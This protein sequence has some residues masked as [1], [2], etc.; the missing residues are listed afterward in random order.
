[1]SQPLIFVTGATGF[2]G[3][4][5]VLQALEAGYS[6]RLSVRKESQIP[7]LKA[8]FSK[9]ASRID[10]VVIPDL[11]APDAF[12]EALQGAAYVF[13]LASPMLGGGSD[14]KRDHLDPAVQ[15]TT[16]LLD[17]AKAVGTIK[18]IVIVSSVLALIS[19]DS[20]SRRRFHAK[21]GANY[22]IHFDT[23]DPR[24]V[25]D[26]NT[27]YHAS[28]VL[29]HRATLEWVREHKPHFT[30]VTLHPV[31]VFGRNLLQ[32]AAEDLSG[33]NAVL[34]GTL[35]A[36]TP[37]II[38]AAVDVRDVA[39]AHLRALDATFDDDG[40]EVHEFLLGAGEARGWTWEKVVRFV[41]EKFP[42]VEVKLQGPFDAPPEVET[43]K[44]E[45]VLGIRWRGMEDTMGELLRQ[46]W[47]LGSQP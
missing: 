40:D 18:R 26:T 31:F 12:K 15:G 25:D 19:S 4:H 1:M 16:V 35:Q 44:A 46:Q 9:H 27:M 42:A 13:H 14:F 24:F 36:E 34:V 17:A 32:T 2:I 20:L 28:K 45:K 23:A 37:G 30:V 33:T 39:L 5:T 3:A 7:T 21:E 11:T 6:V 10:F 22:T 8:L 47:D 29:A 41:R 38:M 43:D